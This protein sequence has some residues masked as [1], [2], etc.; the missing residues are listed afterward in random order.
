MT[1]S[2]TPPVQAV[3]TGRD[4]LPQTPAVH[5]C[6]VHGFP[7]SQ[8][9][10]V[11]HPV[12]IGAPDVSQIGAPAGHPESRMV[13]AAS[14]KQVTHMGALNDPSQ[15]PAGH[16]VAGG[17][18]LLAQ[19]PTVHV[20]FVQSFESSQWAS[21][22]HAAHRGMAPDVSQT[23]VAIEQPPSTM[24]PEALSTQLTQ[25]GLDMAPSHTPKEHVVPSGSD[26][27]KQ[28]PIEHPSAVH[29]SPSLQLAG[30]K[31]STHM[32]IAPEVSH[33]GVPAEHPAS[34]MVPDRSSTHGTHAGMDMAPSHTPPMQAVPV[35]SE[36]FLHIPLPH[37][38]VVHTFESS[39]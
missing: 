10:G 29:S 17:K 33:M 34:V 12:H 13:P 32:V 6:D 28:P 22:A 19:T 9:A 20:S 27:W 1:P 2:H 24:V 8:S 35:V 38:S 39:Q 5:V 36:M 26:V 3:P 30:I 25:A 18:T 16:V 37:R 14:F 15:T 11:V 4:V 7:S 31:H 23:G 21:I